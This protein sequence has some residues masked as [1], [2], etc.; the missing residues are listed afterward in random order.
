[1]VPDWATLGA[2]RSIVGFRVGVSYC[3]SSLCAPGWLI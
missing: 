3:M 2:L 1:M